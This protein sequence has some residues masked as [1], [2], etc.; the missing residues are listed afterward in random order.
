MKNI[1]FIDV[2]GTLTGQDGLVPES[3][4]QAIRESRAK[5]HEVILATGRSLSEITDDILEIGIDGIIGAGG[6]FVEYKNQVLSHLKFEEDSLKEIC[7]FLDHH[8]IG[9]YLESNQGLYASPNCVDKIE[10]AVH[11]MFAHHKEKFVNQ[12]DPLP[13]W[14]LEI[15]D[16]SKGL[17]IPYDNINKL[18][19]IS[20]ETPFSSVSD[21]F[22]DKY[23]M[24]E[25]TVF[26]FGPNSGEIG[27][28]GI[29]KKM[30]IKHVLST[31]VYEGKTY[32]YGDGLND[33]S[34]FETVD[35]SVAMEN[36]KSALKA[37]ANEVTP[38]A[39]EDGIY[40]SFKKNHLI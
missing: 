40:K 18:S 30:A 8:N 28:K 39:E 34:M 10:E 2:D 6:G 36:A 21:K 3:A 31:I 9:Y 1:I 11:Q 13:H 7:E 14:F 26:E 5:G 37:I 12:D 17:E 20:T 25:T 15:L 24:Y 22:S 19:F 27:L 4:K 16:E 29:D 23:E 33:I 35:Y 38:I 32:A